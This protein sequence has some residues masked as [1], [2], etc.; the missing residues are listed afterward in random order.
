MPLP[1]TA[2]ARKEKPRRVGAGQLGKFPNQAERGPCGSRR[3]GDGADGDDSAATDRRPAA[4]SCSLWRCVRAGSR[5]LQNDI[6]CCIT[7]IALGANHPI[8]PFIV[9]GGAKF[10]RKQPI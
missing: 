9:W 6:T 10:S 7:E 2:L 5:L 8:I 4:H 1:W 3:S